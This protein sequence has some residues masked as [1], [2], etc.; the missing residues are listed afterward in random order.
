MTT[1]IDTTLLLDAELRDVEAHGKALQF[2][3]S[4]RGAAALALCPQV[5][6]EFLH[7]VTDPRRFTNPLSMTEA[8]ERANR[9][10]NARQIRQVFPSADSTLL[11]LRWMKEHRLGRKR[12]LDTQLA[13]TYFAA[14]VRNIVTA[15]P[16]DFEVFDGFEFVPYR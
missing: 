9:W 6:S 13:A 12:I 7:V 3:Q 16:D 2:L 10:W 4:R 5:L 1:G 11:H 14:G 8:V 15:N